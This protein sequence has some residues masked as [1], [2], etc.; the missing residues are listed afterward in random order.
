MLP[1]ALNYLGRVRSM[2]GERVE[3]ARLQQRALALFE[4]LGDRN[5]QVNALIDLGR[6]R[7]AIGEYVEAARLYEEA[8]TLSAGLGERQK[9][10]KAYL[11]SLEG[12]ELRTRRRRRRP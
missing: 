4:E 1:T 6:V 5:G 3:A 11:A 12:E 7:Q 9:L 10:V 8:L 2:N